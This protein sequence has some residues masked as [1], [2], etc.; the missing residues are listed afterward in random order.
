MC[1]NVEILVY[2]ILNVYAMCHLQNDL[3]EFFAMVNFTNPGIL[4]D[5]A[6]FRRYFEVQ[7]LL[8]YSLDFGCTL[9]QKFKLIYCQNTIE[10][11]KNELFSC[12]IK[13]NSMYHIFLLT[14]L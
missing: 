13:V 12:Q 4:S 3:E 7:H 2:F 1:Y 9:F 11:R 14:L 5:I 8:H 6:H 10:I